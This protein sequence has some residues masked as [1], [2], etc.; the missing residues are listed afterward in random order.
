MYSGGKKE[1]FYF[2]ERGKTFCF[3]ISSVIAAC[4]YIY[5]YDHNDVSVCVHVSDLT[6]SYIIADTNQGEYNVVNCAPVIMSEDI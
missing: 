6:R 1:F 3:S 5:I 4:V 2:F